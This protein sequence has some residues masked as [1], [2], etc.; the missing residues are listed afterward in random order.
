MTALDGEFHGS[1]P[2]SHQGFV[3]MKINYRTRVRLPSPPQLDAI[4][5]RE[6]FDERND[7]RDFVVKRG[8]VFIGGVLAFDYSGN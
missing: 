4:H 5:N 8:H 3:C 7:E 6:N 1:S 2:C